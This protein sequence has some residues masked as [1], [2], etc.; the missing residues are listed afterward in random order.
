MNAV[1]SIVAGVLCLAAGV[2]VA[3]DKYAAPKATGSGADSANPGDLEALVAVAEK[4]DVIHLA[5]GDYYLADVLTIDRDFSV[6]GAGIDKSV[7]IPA[8]TKRAF[9][10]SHADAVL[11]GVTVKGGNAG[12]WNMSGSAILIDANG[13]SMSDVRVT[14][15][16]QTS[17]QG[18]GVLTVAGPG[19]VSRC[20]FDHD[21]I[22]GGGGLT[23]GSGGI[24]RLTG[25]AKVDNCYI[26]DNDSVGYGGGIVINAAATVRNC[27]IV[28]NHAVYSGAGL[29]VGNKNARV[30]NTV[31]AFNTSDNDATAYAPN[32]TLAKNVPASCL[33]HC[34]LGGK[35]CGN[36]PQ[37]VGMTDFNEEDFSPAVGGALVDTGDSSRCVEGETDLVGGVRVRAVVDIGC[38]ELDPSKPSVSFTVS[39]NLVMKGESIALTPSF[40]GFELSEA[41]F[42]W[43]ISNRVTAAVVARTD[44]DAFDF[45]PDAGRYD[46]SLAVT[47]GGEVCCRKTA[48][49]CFAVGVPT[50]YVVP[51]PNPDAA[52]PYDTWET[53]L[54]DIQ[55][56]IDSAVDGATVELSAET[57]PVSATINLTRPVTLKGQGMDKT[58][59][60]SNGCRL[61]VVNDAQAEIADLTMT[62]SNTGGY[63][64]YGSAVRIEGK[65]GNV[66]GVR[67]TACTV[68]D[69]QGNGVLHVAGA[70]RVSRC[71][72]D[73]NSVATSTHYSDS[74]SGGMLYLKAAAT[75]DNCLFHD[76]D[77]KGNC[78]GILLADAATVRNCTVV[79]NHA[80]YWGA[81]IY[82]CSSAARV[83]NTVV[84]FNT[85]DN[86]STSYAPNVA[87]AANVP[88]TCLDH[89]A[90]SGVACGTESRLVTA[91]AFEDGFGPAA[92]SP[93]IDHGDSERCEGGET[94]LAGLGRI[95]GD[96]VDIG[97]FE[98]D[99]TALGVSFS[100]GADHAF[101]DE[102]VTF[103]PAYENVGESATA[104]WTISNTVT[105]A[106][107]SRHDTAP[108]AVLLPAG[109]YDATL[110][111]VD[112]TAT[113]ACSSAA[114]LQVGSRNVYVV[115]GENLG[116]S[117]PYDTPETASTNIAEALA[118]VVDGATVNLVSPEYA[119][120]QTIELT[121]PLTIRGAGMD[122][123]VLRSVGGV[124]LLMI[125]DVQAEVADLTVRDADNGGWD[126]SGSAIQIGGKGGNLTCVRVTDCTHKN[127]QTA[128]VLSSSGPGRISRC[129]V[130]NN[131]VAFSVHHES[132]TGGTVLITGAA[133]VENCLVCNNESKGNGGGMRIKGAAATVRNCTIVS[134]RADYAAGGLYA[135]HKDAR[136]YNTVV[137]FNSSGNDSTAYAPNVTFESGASAAVF[138]HCAFSGTT[139]GTL[140]QEVTEADFP[141]AARGNYR[142]SAASV[143]RNNGTVACWDDLT[144]VL[145][146]AGGKRL[147]GKS[148]D[149]GCYETVGGFMLMLR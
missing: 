55:A 21:A 1:R 116:M 50:V 91:Q 99:T 70:G 63:G 122:K 33:D 123:T 108:F 80:T 19:H 126:T 112:G 110:E 145:D 4:G 25:A 64:D 60:R 111:V 120:S 85:S 26:H 117:Y 28:N 73:N 17:N 29:Y 79:R 76:N 101:T 34:A 12:A 142:P 113:A 18:G 148:V 114:V 137:A 127:C 102:Y 144:G 138:D 103:T 59:L 125:N 37:L 139:C 68:K 46:V 100:V 118:Q 131:T 51:G 13:G 32:V 43:T 45:E 15:C 97:C 56:A 136:V 84:A 47:I 146:L 87:F 72:F 61:F 57:F 31:V 14:D 24:V 106:V 89:C 62:G 30:Y 22:S 143:C 41:S 67:F 81:G 44:K 20:I 48:S 11:T 39:A 27:T 58:V 54:T 10:I 147:V 16:A 121:R 104:T 88:A 96:A 149:I 140:A 66:T 53:A 119:I 134:N 124:R 130:D 42:A 109:V 23:E 115:E 141:R 52:Y 135:C 65:G 2:A 95:L 3:T 90:F 40:G 7:V 107:V 128:G 8:K 6:V 132:G 133:T 98:R 86:D 92:G 36:N 78:G 105:H 71:V 9:L 5:V 94:D 77:S 83:Y 74:V 38:Y 69:H 49:D 75:V 82:V 35:T 129:V 93:L